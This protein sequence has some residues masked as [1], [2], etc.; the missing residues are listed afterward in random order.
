MW[1]L[2]RVLPVHP[3][4]SADI[5]NVQ[6][7]LRRHVDVVM[8]NLLEKHPHLEVHDG[9]PV[10]FVVRLDPVE[11]EA[12]VWWWQCPEA[13]G[14]EVRTYYD[15]G[16]AVH[17]VH[18]HAGML[19]AS[20]MDVRCLPCVS[21]GSRDST[22][23]RCT[24]EG[25]RTLLVHRNAGSC[26]DQKGR[27]VRCVADVAKEGRE[28]RAGLLEVCILDRGQECLVQTLEKAVD[29]RRVGAAI[30]NGVLAAVDGGKHGCG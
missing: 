12:G 10:A 7:A 6:L 13:N 8:R 29:L 5:V 14:E 23:S 19:Y 21:V 17:D 1:V 9:I 3:Y 26:I 24:E 22:G 25:G 4:A 18:H 16:H 20:A 2:R 28:G 27:N 11:L 30:C 15:I